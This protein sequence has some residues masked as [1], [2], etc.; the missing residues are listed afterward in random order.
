MTTNAYIN[1]TKINYLTSPYTDGINN[2]ITAFTPSSPNRF[3]HFA[4]GV[5]L[6][7]PV[8]NIVVYVA[9][10]QFATISAPVRETPNPSS[11][12]KRSRHSSSSKKHRSSSKR[13]SSSRRRSSRSSKGS[14]KPS[15][16]SSSRSSDVTYM[17]SRSF[18]RQPDIH[19]RSVTQQTH[20]SF[21]GAGILPYRFKD[22]HLEFLIGKESAGYHPNT[23]SDFGGK[24]ERGERPIQTAAREGAEETGEILGSQSTLERRLKQAPC[25][26]SKYVMYLL[27]MNDHRVTPGAFNR[28]RHDREKSEIAWVKAD[29]LF[30]AASGN[31]MIHIGDRSLQRLRP[32]FVGTLQF[33][34]SGT[35]PSAAQIFAQL[36]ES[37]QHRRSA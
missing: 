36:R 11:K 2:L 24:P 34:G 12:T 27:E 3:S 31:G 5:A 22:G 26:G 10:K 35:T 37:A 29:D 32:P 18:T 20:S 16:S 8:A 28:A 1:L 21:H 6:L 14:S 9:L 15:S 23:W 33:R 19:S 4:A 25:I 7:I 13:H 30:R 17:P